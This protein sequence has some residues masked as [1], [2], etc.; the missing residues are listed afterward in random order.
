MAGD[1]LHLMAGDQLCDPQEMHSM[2]K[3]RKLEREYCSKRLS[4]YL[5]GVWKPELSIPKYK[6][7]QEVFHLEVFYQT[8]ELHKKPEEGNFAHVT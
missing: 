5:Q 4:I 1:L 3:V 8:G 2:Q 7:H 6:M